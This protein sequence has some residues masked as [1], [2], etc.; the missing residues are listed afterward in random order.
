MANLDATITVRCDRV[1]ESAGGIVEIL[2]QNR[3]MNGRRGHDEILLCNLLS[4]RGVPEVDQEYEITIRPATK[5][6]PEG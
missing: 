5:R 4:E 3:V 6:V 2:F 1:R